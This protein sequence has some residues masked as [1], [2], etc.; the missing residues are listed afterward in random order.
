MIHAENLVDGHR[1]LPVLLED[2][3]SASRAIHLSIFLFFDDQI[4][5]EISRILEEKARAGVAV[6]VLL[7]IA[8]TNMAAPFKMRRRLETAGVEVLDTEIDYDKIVETG[9][10]AIDDL[11]REIRN[12]VKVDSL[13]VDHRK[14]VT[15]DGRVGYCG[16]A[17]IGAEYQYRLPFDP[18]R[19]AHDEADH[20]RKAGE[21]E[22]WVKWHD[23]FVRFEGSLVP[24]LDL[25]FRERWRLGGGEDFRPLDAVVPIAPR[26]VRVQSARVV[27]NE[28]SSRPNE[29]RATF[30]DRI[31]AAERSIFIENPYVYHP[32]IVAALFE[33]RK[34]RPQLQVT[35]IVPALEWSDNAYAQDAQ[36]HH[37][38]ALLEAGIE[39]HE[40]QNHFAHL[41]LATF[42]S[43]W[44][45]VGSAN[46]NFRSLEDD[47][48]FELC[49]LIEGEEFARGIE[50]DVRDEDLRWS[51]QIRA[52][53]VRGLSMHALR[54]RLR[55]PR[56]LL[57]IAARAL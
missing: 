36:Q 23:G 57:M 4:G 47:K 28:P 54:V 38:P 1:L 56:T 49:I 2:L 9:E 25:V 44:S 48:D 7:N 20:G 6:R 22:P 34:K 55:D 5:G 13:H 12:S 17:N 46:L 51:R 10:P 33:A 16:S 40:Y 43:K 27:K 53:D 30:L 42:D 26:G 45:I 29:I 31:A 8:K 18:K 41:K 52:E 11:A 32:A 24:D 50:R 21:P 14:I 15:I 19:S 39:V 3:A 35:L 37:Y